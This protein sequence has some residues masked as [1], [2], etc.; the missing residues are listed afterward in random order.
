M[1]QD[2][3]FGHEVNSPLCNTFATSEGDRQ[4]ICTI[5]CYYSSLEE[6]SMSFNDC[7]QLA[8]SDAK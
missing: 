8:I 6:R 7:F 3:S 1:F 2:F 5:V 4:L